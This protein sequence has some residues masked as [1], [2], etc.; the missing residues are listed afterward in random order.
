MRVRIDPELSA[1][2]LILAIVFS[3]AIAFFWT[4]ATTAGIR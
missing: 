2:I 3:M 1:W 4:V